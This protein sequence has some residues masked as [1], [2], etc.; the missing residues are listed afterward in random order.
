MRRHADSDHP[1]GL[2]LQQESLVET[3]ATPKTRDSGLKGQLD[4]EARAE[5]ALVT[6][7]SLQKHIWD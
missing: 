3:S 7:S 4:D 5:V 2:K 6:A 1:E